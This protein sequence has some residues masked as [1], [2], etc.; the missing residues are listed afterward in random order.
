[1]VRGQVCSA[2]VEV[3]DCGLR[4]NRG[5]S[6]RFV[7]YL[8]MAASQPPN[9]NLGRQEDRDIAPWNIVGRGCSSQGSAC[10]D[11]RLWS[12]CEE[13]RDEPSVVSE[14]TLPSTY[15]I[16][17]RGT[18]VHLHDIEPLRTCGRMV[19]LCPLRYST[20]SE[21]PASCYGDRHQRIGRM[22]QR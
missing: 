11:R 9:E 17:T 1:M 22:R 4:A 10:T 5:T 19:G 14:S 18:F 21:M 15:R 2:M 8:Q 3:A 7:I 16:T 6:L 20:D 12:V 13:N